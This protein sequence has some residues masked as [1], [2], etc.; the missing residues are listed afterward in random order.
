MDTTTKKVGKLARTCIFPLCD[1]RK[2]IE[3]ML[4]NVN[5]AFYFDIYLKFSNLAMYT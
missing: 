2:I 5:F 1:E 3:L 4:D